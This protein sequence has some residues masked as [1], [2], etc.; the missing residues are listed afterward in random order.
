VQHQ[1]DGSIVVE[2]WDRNEVR[3]QATNGTGGPLRVEY[4]SAV[5]R[6]VSDAPPGIGRIDYRIS[7]PAT[8]ELELRAVQA[9]ITAR[10]IRS[11]VRAQA[12][13]GDILVQGGSGEIS[14]ETISGTVVIEEARGEVRGQSVSGDIRLRD[15]EGPIDAETISG[16][17]LLENVRS[18]SVRASAVSGH[19]F[20]DGTIAANG[21]YRFA[22]HSGSITMAVQEPVSAQVRVSLFSGSFISTLAALEANRSGQTLRETLTLGTGSATVELESFGGRIRLARRGEVQ[23]PPPP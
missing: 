10:G 20:F 2:T 23:P 7:V 21:R 1:Q 14:V 18:T 13:H 12:V 11:R 16:R 22:T 4:S 3:V 15:V 6:V 8:T 9:A 19:V 5:V 17:V